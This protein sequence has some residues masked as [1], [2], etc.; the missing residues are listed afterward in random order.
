[1]E[2]NMIEFEEPKWDLG[3]LGMVV[4]SIVLKV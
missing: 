1:M 4:Q 3:H 2:E